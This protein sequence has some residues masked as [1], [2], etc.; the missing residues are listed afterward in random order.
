MRCFTRR[1]SIPIALMTVLA[2]GCVERPSVPTPIN[3]LATSAPTTAPPA[4]IPTITI[5]SSPSPFLVGIAGHITVEAS[6]PTAKMSIDP[7]DHTELYE[8]QVVI[9]PGIGTGARASAHIWHTYF[10]AGTFTVA[11]IVTT[12]SG[13]IVNQ[14]TAIQVVP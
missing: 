9:N 3:S 5:V 10:A 12:P 1:F 6:A 14:T 2:L 4:S 13:V 11:V 7:G 8:A